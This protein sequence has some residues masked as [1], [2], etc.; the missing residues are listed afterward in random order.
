S[1]ENNETLLKTRAELELS[2]NDLQ[3]KLRETQGLLQASID[4]KAGFQEKLNGLKNSLNDVQTSYVADEIR[5][6]ELK[7]QLAD[8]AGNAERNAQLLE[9]DRDIRDLMTARNLHIFDVFDT[10]AKGKTEPAF[11]RIFYTEGKSLIFYAYDLNGAK[12]EHANYHYKVW[13]GKK[14]KRIKS[15]ISACSI[16]TIKP[17]VA[18]S[19]NAMI[20]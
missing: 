9:R 17:S 14:P 11:G 16:Q 3:H 19:L 2:R 13:A 10:D 8:K 7:E 18:G 15:P 1:S 6:R 20:Q 12:L 5:I 4:E